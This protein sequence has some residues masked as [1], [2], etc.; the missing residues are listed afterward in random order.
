MEHAR[1]AAFGCR[2][3]SG[4]TA[5]RSKR[6]VLL[7]RNDRARLMQRKSNTNFFIQNGLAKR[8]SGFRHPAPSLCERSR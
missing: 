1:A 4:C 3:K 7:V 5:T 6:H 8:V 2:P